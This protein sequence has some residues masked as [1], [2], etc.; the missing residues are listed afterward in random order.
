[1]PIALMYI[2]TVKTEFKNTSFVVWF[3]FV[4]LTDLFQIYLEYYTVY[5]ARWTGGGHFA[6]LTYVPGPSGG[7]DTFLKF[8]VRGGPSKVVHL[9]FQA[10]G[11][12]FKNSLM[13]D[14]IQSFV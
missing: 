13:L 14:P 5:C 3:F 8:G 11:Q 4:L 7:G 6:I 2:H 10:G 9:Q 12:T 1:M